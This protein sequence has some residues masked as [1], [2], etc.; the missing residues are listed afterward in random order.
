MK[1]LS[2]FC[3]T[4]SGFQSLFIFVF[5][6]SVSILISFVCA[7]RKQFSFMSAS[8]STPISLYLIA[9]PDRFPAKLS[10]DSAGT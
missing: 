5:R 6:Y 7:E 9:I 3:S 4:L 2:Y 10:S 8:S 1:F